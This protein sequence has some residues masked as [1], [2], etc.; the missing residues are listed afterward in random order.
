MDQHSSDQWLDDRVCHAQLQFNAS[1][2]LDRYSWLREWVRL[3]RGRLA[4]PPTLGPEAETFLKRVGLDQEPDGTII[5]GGLGAF[6]AWDP[7]LGL[8]T[9]PMDDTFRRGVNQVQGDAFLARLSPHKHYSSETQ[10]AALRALVTMPPGAT[11]LASMPT[12]TGKSLLFQLGVRWWQED[13]DL[14]HPGEGHRA[15]A[16]VIVPTIAL[17]KDHEKTLRKMPGLGNSRALVGQNLELKRKILEDFLKGEVPILLL[18]PEAAEGRA[19]EVLHKVAL[20]LDHEERLPIHKAVLRGVFID[21]AHIIETWGRQFRP[22]FQ[23]L[24]RL[25]DSLRKL[26]PALPTVLL[27]ATIGP[28]SLTNLRDSFMR[29]GFPWLEINAKTPR[30]EF[31]IFV[32][33]TADSERRRD[34]LTQLAP[35]LPKPC[36][37]YTTEVAEAEAIHQALRTQLSR[38]ALF[39]GSTPDRDRDTVIQG[40]SDGKIDLVV[41][42]SAFGLGIDHSHVRTVVHACL[43]EGPERWYQEIGRGGRDGHQAFSLTLWTEEDLQLGHSLSCSGLLKGDTAKRRFDAIYEEAAARQGIHRPTLGPITLSADLAVLPSNLRWA[44]DL[45]LR[46]NAALLNLLQRQGILTWA[47]G[48]GTLADMEIQDERLLPAHPENAEFWAKVQAKRDEVLEDGLEAFQSFAKSMKRPD[49]VCL[50]EDV[51]KAIETDQEGFSCGRCTGCRK[52]GIPPSRPRNPGGGDRFWEEPFLPSGSSRKGLLVGCCRKPQP[53]PEQLDALAVAGIHHFFVEQSHGEAT[54]KYLQRQEA[55]LGW[56]STVES[57]YKDGQHDIPKMPTVAWWPRTATPYQEDRLLDQFQAWPK[58][59]KGDSLV[60]FLDP[61][62]RAGTQER[63]WDAHF[64]C[65]FLTFSQLSRQLN[66]S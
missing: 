13:L 32:Q 60:L 30:N 39:T 66:L 35:L 1:Q 11:M 64:L 23:T 49:R 31:D 55:R 24:F 56:V 18:G 17:A 9:T 26:S 6:Q 65:P 42:T 33:E 50:L 19:R 51:F 22:E 46:W 14:A 44:S 62:H 47:G 28:L 29:E 34:L 59:P 54:L 52:A 2:G 48:K 38:V 20:P 41:A 5:F 7:I 36:I 8:L 53:D 58:D 27:S 16:I 21:E 57:L 40:W 25:V 10:K 3:R 37:I 63:P 12:G 45:N 15:C 61:D 43:P 4:E